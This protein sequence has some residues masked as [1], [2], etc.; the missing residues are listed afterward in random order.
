MYAR[1]GDK[2]FTGPE[3]FFLGLE[4]DHNRVFAII[5]VDYSPNTSDSGKDDSKVAKSLLRV[6]IFSFP[7]VAVGFTS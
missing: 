5:R 6:F 3:H 1:R 2:T 4:P 7:V